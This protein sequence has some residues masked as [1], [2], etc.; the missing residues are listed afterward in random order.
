MKHA[1]Q[2]LPRSSSRSLLCVGE[3]LI[4]VLLAFAAGLAPALLQVLA[5]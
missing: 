1:S 2:T 3:A 5:G 4:P